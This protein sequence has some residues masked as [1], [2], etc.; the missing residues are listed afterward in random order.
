MPQEWASGGP[1]TL[2]LLGVLHIGIFAFATGRVGPESIPILGF[3]V[4]ACAIPL[5]LLAMVEMRRGELLFGTMG[6]V[7]GGLLGLGGA[8][9][10]IRSMFVPGAS[11]IDG[12]WFSSTG[13]VLFLL[14]PAVRKLPE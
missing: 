3:W 14:L 11:P 1:A 5:L 4:L 8:L 2:Y 13:I 9:S 10:F 7:F 12:W 6:M